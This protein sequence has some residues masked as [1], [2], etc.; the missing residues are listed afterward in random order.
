VVYGNCPA[1]IANPQGLANPD[2]SCPDGSSGGTRFLPS[3]GSSTP[4]WML[5]IGLLPEI[6]GESAANLIW[7]KTAQAT[8]GGVIA[9]A[10]AGAAGGTL[11]GGIGAIPGSVVGAVI[12]GVIAA[13]GTAITSS[14]LASVCTAAGAYSS[15]PAPQTFEP[16][17]DQPQSPPNA[18][19][20]RPSPPRVPVRAPVIPRLPVPLS[21]GAE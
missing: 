4:W 6:C 18:G 20:S 8:I 17:P 3:A 15:K 2:G 11:T 19:P 10:E 14:A 7:T 13:G 5:P 12:V 16:I 1:T 21:A 9:G